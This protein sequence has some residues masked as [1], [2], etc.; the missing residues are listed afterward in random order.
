MVCRFDETHYFDNT[1]YFI[2]DEETMPSLEQTEVEEHQDEPINPADEDNESDNTKNEDNH[3]EDDIYY[4]R[5]LNVVNDYYN[6]PDNN[7]R[8]SVLFPC[9]DDLLPSSRPNQLLSEV[10]YE[11]MKNILEL[12]ND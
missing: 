3:N 2:Y 4:R 10:L 11:N 5:L 1:A 9:T 12:M 7:Y 6:S 8:Q